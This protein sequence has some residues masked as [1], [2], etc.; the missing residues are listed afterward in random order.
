V[1]FH[2]DLLARFKH[3]FPED[4]TVNAVGPTGGRELAIHVVKKMQGR[5][6]LGKMSNG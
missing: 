4:W 1:T 2:P 6:I 5:I 3:N